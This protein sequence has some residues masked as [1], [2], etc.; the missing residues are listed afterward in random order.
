M[1]VFHAI[2][3]HLNLFKTC[4]ISDIQKATTLSYNQVLQV[5]TVNS[6]LLKMKGKSIISF[7]HSMEYVNKNEKWYRLVYS[8][9][10]AATDVTIWLSTGEQY[11]TF[12]RWGGSPE[13]AEFQAKLKEIEKAGYIPENTRKLKTLEQ[14]W[15]E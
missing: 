10:W 3:A 11:G 8:G 12:S 13:V 2:T 4:S 5:L 1:R 6:Q 7:V 15:K 9:E 14:M